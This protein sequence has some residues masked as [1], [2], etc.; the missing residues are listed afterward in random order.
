M[1][2]LTLCRADDGGVLEHLTDF[3][4]I[5]ERLGQ[6]GVT[7]E[8]W[9]AQQPLAA[10][11]SQDE[12]LAAYAP[13][14]AQLKRQYGFQSLDVVALTPAHPQKAELRAKF[15]SEH[16]HDDFEVRFFVAG[17]GLFYLRLGEQIG[18]MLCG[19]GDLISVPAHT[20]HWFDMG[21]EPD[22]KCIRFFT[23]PEGWIGR[24]T[25]DPIAS[26]FPDFDAY[27]REYAL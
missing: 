19:P 20:R 16:T 17:Q 6:F 1:S 13:Q 14:V 11:A 7:L 3:P 5:A 10:N 18:L 26:R 22:F 12:V 27:R 9:E 15:L 23:V 24:F 8:R 2:A 4:A 21:A 25:G